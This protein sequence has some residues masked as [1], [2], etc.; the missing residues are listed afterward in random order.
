LQRRAFDLKESAD[1][2][3]TAIQNFRLASVAFF[4]QNHLCSFIAN[5]NGPF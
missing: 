3:G 1:N 2:A 5:A 4:A